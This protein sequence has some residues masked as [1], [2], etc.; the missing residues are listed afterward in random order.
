MI[1]DPAWQ[2]LMMEQLNVRKDLLAAVVELQVAVDTFAYI[3]DK[4]DNPHITFVAAKA[5]NRINEYSREW[6]E[7]NKR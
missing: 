7:A 1:P 4:A 5:I 2:E 6:N 3:M